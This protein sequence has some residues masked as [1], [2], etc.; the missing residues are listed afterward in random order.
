VSIAFINT[1][2]FHQQ[3]FNIDQAT[4]NIAQESGCQYCDGR[5]HKANYPRIGFGVSAK[6][7]PLYSSRFSF[8]CASCRRRHTP[9]SVRFFGRRRYI[10]M[11][12]ILLSALRFSPSESRCVR[13]ANRFGL[14]ISLVTWKRWLAWWRFDFPLAD[15]WVDL[16]AHFKLSPQSTARTLLK[17][18]SSHTLSAKLQQALVLLSPLKHHIT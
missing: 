10:A 8:C 5:L 18:L 16:K 4:A 6:Q 9:P 7:A 3:L 14:C 17:Q 1:P 12:F 15:L 11:I 2:E 13:L